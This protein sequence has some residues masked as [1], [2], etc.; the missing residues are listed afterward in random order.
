MMAVSNKLNQLDMRIA[1]GAGSR[2][3]VVE[4]L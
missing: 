3:E 1:V 4:Y 2:Q